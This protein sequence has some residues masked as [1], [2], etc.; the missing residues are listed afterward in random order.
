MPYPK[1]Y[2]K[3]PGAVAVY[4]AKKIIAAKKRITVK[5]I[6]DQI[7]LVKPNNIIAT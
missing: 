3:G 4:K 6:L 2:G 1:K 5:K 7:N